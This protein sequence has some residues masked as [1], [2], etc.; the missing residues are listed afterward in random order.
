LTLRHFRKNIATARWGG[1][2]VISKIDIWRTA[3]EMIK[4][5]GDTAD[6]ETA[7][8]ADALQHKG[9]LEGQRVWFR[10]LKAIDAL[11][12]MQPGETAQ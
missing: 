5:Y 12:K 7:A 4:A 10:V 8:R 6:I 11:Q 1:G 9:D 2:T 3:A